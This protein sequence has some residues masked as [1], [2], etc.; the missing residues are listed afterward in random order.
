MTELLV[1]LYLLL[2]HL[3]A[4]FMLQPY[5]LVKLKSQPLG[6]AIHSGVHA[7]ITI[8]IAG[9]VLPRWWLVIPLLT[10]AH[11]FVDRTKVESGFTTGPASFLAFLV[12]QVAHLGVLAGA[13]L[14]AGVPLD[15]AVKYASAGLTAVVYYAVPYVAAMFAGAIVMYQIAVAFN[16][17]GN[18]PDL[19]APRLRITG[20]V[21][22]GLALTV[23]LFLQP[24]LWWL[25]VVPYVAVL[26][27][28]R[29]PAQ[30]PG[31]WVEAASSLGLSVGLGL[32]FR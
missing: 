30:Q 3:V 9:P 24:A 28:D 8:I 10:V 4:D 15:H 23:V 14:V 32:L 13:V 1:W 21:E 2:A 27:A 6:L 19:L 16:T 7:L 20:M 29:Q 25:G 22:R 12:D 5:E 26:L 31:R 11:Y 18:P 17:R